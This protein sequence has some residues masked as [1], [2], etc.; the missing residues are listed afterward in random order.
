MKAIHDRV[1]MIFKKLCVL[2]LSTKV[3]S[4]LE[5]LK[6]VGKKRLKNSNWKFKSSSRKCPLNL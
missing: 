6:C 5:G 1:K 3:A 2:V 4:A